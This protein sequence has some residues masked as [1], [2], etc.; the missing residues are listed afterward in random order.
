MTD[1]DSSQ[2]SPKV[3]VFFDRCFV[4]ALV[5]AESLRR[6]QRPHKTSVQVDYWCC[7]EESEK[8]AHRVSYKETLDET[9]RKRRPH[10]TVIYELQARQELIV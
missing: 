3:I 10:Y 6:H 8:L 9:I 4:W 1:P 2:D 5:A 7:G